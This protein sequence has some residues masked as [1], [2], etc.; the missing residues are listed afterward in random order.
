MELVGNGEPS[1]LVDYAHTPDGLES[2]LQALRPHCR[3]RLI[4]VFGC[5]GDRDKG[6][7]PQMAAVCERL[8][9]VLVVT[10]D[11]PRSENPLDII[12]DVLA[13]L[14]ETA[15]PV[16]QEDRRKAIGQAIALAKKGDCVLIAGKGH[17]DYQIIGNQRLD[18]DDRQVAK[19]FLAGGEA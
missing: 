14:S 7:R 4:V 2:A 15:Q 12:R 9:D 11:N 6:K 5:G 18:F 13:G 17:E 10:S 1:V 8:A 3:G 16:V 19:A